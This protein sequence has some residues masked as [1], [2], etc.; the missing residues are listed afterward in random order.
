M[1]GR[2]SGSANQWSEQINQSISQSITQSI[3]NQ[4][5]RAT[6]W[7]FPA[8]SD[9]TTTELMAVILRGVTNLDQSMDQPMGQSV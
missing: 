4:P 7:F 3:V 8:A 2:S 9:V 1:H 5:D 6:K